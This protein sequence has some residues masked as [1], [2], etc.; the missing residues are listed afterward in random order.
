MEAFAEEW[1]EGH[2]GARTNFKLKIERLDRGTVENS[3]SEIPEGQRA[4]ADGIDPA[5][6]ALILL[7]NS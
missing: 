7:E 1:H 2:R 4:G 3:R 6:A 5:C